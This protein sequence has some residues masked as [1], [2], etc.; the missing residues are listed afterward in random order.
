MQWNASL[1]SFV[2]CGTKLGDDGRK[3][4][5]T[6]DMKKGKRNSEV[7]KVGTIVSPNMMPLTQELGW[8]SLRR[9]AANR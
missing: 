2:K 1:C 4:L 9:F 7:Y 8:L 6:L 3:E 5:L